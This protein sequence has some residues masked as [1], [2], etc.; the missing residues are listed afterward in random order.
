MLND[1]RTYMAQAPWMLLGPVIAIIVTIFAAN[2]LGEGLNA[3]EKAKSG[4][5][6]Q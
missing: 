6:S 4:R 1:S 5:V 2:L 3:R